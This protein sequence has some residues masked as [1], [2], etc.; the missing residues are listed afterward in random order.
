MVEI[1]STTAV[2]LTLIGAFELR[3]EGERL[4]LPASAQ[5]L[6]A[7]VALHDHP[8]LRLHVAGALWLETA[9]NRANANLRSALW[10]V[11][12]TGYDLVESANR[13]LRLAPSVS[14]DFREVT[15]LAHRLL[16][17]QELSTDLDV[18]EG[19]LSDDLLPDWYEDWV[20]IERERFRQL[21]L[22]ALEELCDRRLV[23]GRRGQA[24]EAALTAVAAEPLRESAQ[25]MLIK[26]HL[27]DGN[28]GEAI[29]QYRL[30]REQLNSELGLAPSQQIETLVHGLM[31]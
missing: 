12:R 19:A 21:R 4:P 18:D 27:A 15:L 31:R 2:R 29:R 8:L 9:E 23:F 1:R 17:G 20:L 22:A 28:Y 3:C 25:R 10:R 6:I 14:V 30:Y 7:F 16:K 11:H 13:Q 26:V 5:R 24:L